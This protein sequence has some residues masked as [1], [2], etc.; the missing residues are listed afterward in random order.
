[1]LG[2]LFLKRVLD[3]CWI[4]L[5]SNLLIRLLQSCELGT[6]SHFLCVQAESRTGASSNK[7]SYKTCCCTSTLLRPRG[8]I[9]V[10]G[11]QQ[12]CN[13]FFYIKKRGGGVVSPGIQQR[14]KGR[15]RTGLM[16]TSQGLSHK[17]RRFAPDTWS[18]W[19]TSH[20]IQLSRKLRAKNR[21]I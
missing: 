12:A 15:S 16:A 11:F 4:E 6:S 8:L 14:R 2:I 1:M 9:F 21:G 19:S 3:G 5:T 10:K 13:N 20:P 7:L 17:L 18:E